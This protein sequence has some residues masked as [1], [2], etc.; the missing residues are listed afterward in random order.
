MSYLFVSHDL[1]VVRLLC[2]RVIVMRTGRIVEQGSAEAVLGRSAGRLY[3]G[4]ADGDPASAVAGALIS[5]DETGAKMAADHA[6]TITSTPSRKRWRCRSRT[7]GSRRC[8][9]ISKCRCG[10]RGWSTNSRCPT[11]PS[12]PVSLQPD[13]AMTADRDRAV[14]LRNRQGRRDPASSRRCRRPKRRWR[15][16]RSTIPS[17]IPSP[18]SP[19]SARA[20]RRA[21]SMPRSPPGK[22]AGPL[23]GV[24]F[25][26]KNLFDVEGLADPRRL[27]DQPRSARRRRAT[28]R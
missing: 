11:K 8:G 6:S 4:A 9:P 2:D 14:G 24:P 25:A 13:L 1:N 17:S 3:K 12:R 23:A 15:G 26:V 7:P 22:I 18:T 10:W 16:S 27:E 19:P 21:P 5:K 28:P 20:P